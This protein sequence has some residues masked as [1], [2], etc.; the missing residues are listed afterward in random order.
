MDRWKA[1]KQKKEETEED[2]KAAKDKEDFLTLTGLADKLLQNGNMD[3]YEMTYEKLTYELKKFEN[4]KERLSI[5]EGTNDDDALDM[6]AEDID[7]KVAEKIE[8]D[9]G[10]AEPVKSESSANTAKS[11]EDEGIVLLDIKFFKMKYDYC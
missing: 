3:V 11:K 2:R 8:K 4:G 6:F 10:N 9:F 5:P 1:K 7:K